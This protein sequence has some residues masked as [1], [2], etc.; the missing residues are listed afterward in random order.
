MLNAEYI[1]WAYYQK[2]YGPINPYERGDINAAMIQ[3]VIA[4]VNRDRK[5]RRQP[6]PISKFMPQ[7]EPRKPQSA[8][9][10]LSTIER[11]NAAFGGVDLR[12]KTSDG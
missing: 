6:F 3:Q 12:D 4:E 9:S 7:F 2:L 1:G 10:M 5:K 11:L 8:D